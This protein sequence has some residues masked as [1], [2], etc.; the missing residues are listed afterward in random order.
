VKNVT[1]KEVHYL[2]QIAATSAGTVPPTSL[3]KRP[4]TPFVSPLTIGKACVHIA[5]PLLA[6]ARRGEGEARAE[7]G[8]LGSTY[9][10]F[11]IR[12]AHEQLTAMLTALTTEV[13]R[14]SQTS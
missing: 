12:K 4:P 11:D 6:V 13:R 7:Q 5:S 9:G 10:I 8:F 3:T 2:R 1:S 14:V